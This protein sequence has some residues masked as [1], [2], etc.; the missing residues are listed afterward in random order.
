MIGSRAP[1]SSSGLGFMLIPCLARHCSLARQGMSR[2]GRHKA[3]N[4]HFEFCN[5]QFAIDRADD[6]KVQIENCKL[7]IAYRL[8]EIDGTRSAPTTALFCRPRRT[9]DT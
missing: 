2:E 9:G 3:P 6:C 8:A 7:T 1:R 5:C 4:L